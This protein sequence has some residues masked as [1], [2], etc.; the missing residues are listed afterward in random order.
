MHYVQVGLGRI[1]LREKRLADAN[2]IRQSAED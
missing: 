2:G 1:A